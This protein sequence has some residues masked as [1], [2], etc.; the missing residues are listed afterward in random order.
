MDRRKFL[1]LSCAGLMGSLL[2]GCGFQNRSKSKEVSKKPNIVLIMA[3]DMGFSDVGCYGGEID[4]PNLD[5]LGYN[6]LRFTQFYN[7]ARCCPTRASLLT[8]LYP[9]QVNLARNGRAL[10]KNGVTIAEVLKGAGY[11]TSMA[12]K[13]HLSRTEP[14]EHRH[15]DWLNHQY[16]PDVP[17][18]PIESYPVNRGFDYHYGVIWGVIDYFD[19]FSLVEN[20]KPVENVPE[21][22]YF[23]RAIN[24]KAVDCI[25]RLSKSDYP[26]FLYVAH[27]APHWPLHALEED[28]EKYKGKYIEGWDKLREQRFKRQLELGLF[29]EADT[30]LPP[31]QSGDEDWD[32]LT[33]SQRETEAEKM[34]VHAAMVDRID[35]GVGKIVDELKKNGE[36]EN[37]IIMFLSDN[38]ASPEEYFNP[39]FD[40]PSETRDGEKIKYRNIKDYGKETTWGYFGQPWASAVN[41]PFRYWKKES[42]EGGCHTPLIVHWPKGLKTKPGTLTDQPGHIIDILPTCL[43]LTGA[44]YPEIYNGNKITPMEGKSLAPIF[45]GREREGHKYLFFEHMGGRAVRA[46]NWKLVALPGQPWELYNIADDKTETNNL[47]DKYPEKARELESKWHGWA[48]KVGLE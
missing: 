11:N 37:T 4:T 38:G 12:G 18:A 1:K 8:G 27:C 14:L 7:A 19:P 48:K 23:T 47:I 46:G 32:R 22:Y 28:I 39:G 10:G 20:E 36:Y 13:W 35:Q 33:E 2:G 44:H 5:K 26:F 30:Q 43:D 3:D 40:R 24:D 25:S 21:D 34:A 16:D 15:M 42:F 9:H 17:F 41:T 31:V 29:E 45:E 6:G